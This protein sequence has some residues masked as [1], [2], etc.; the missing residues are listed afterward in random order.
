MM[1]HTPEGPVLTDPNFWAT[2]DH[3]ATFTKFRQKAPVVW[4]PEP[5]TSWNPGGGRGFWS[6][7]SHDLVSTVSKSTDLFGSRYGT[8]V[9]DQ[10]QAVVSA[11]GML[12]MDAPEHT[13]LRSIV[14]RV[15]T[16]R[17]VGSMMTDI[18]G[19]AERLV[20]RLVDLGSFDFAAEVADTYPAGIVAD[21][22]GVE[23]ADLQMLVGLTKKI[24]G[25]IPEVS[26]R[27]NLEMINYGTELSNR[28]LKHPTADLVSTI[29]HAEV[30]GARLTPEEVGT[31]FALL[32]TAGIE[33]T[34]TALNH[35]MVALDRYPDQ[36]E[37]WKAD[38]TAHSP[39]AVEEVFRWASPVRR[40]RRTA[41]QDTTIADTP[42]AAG[43]KV[44][45]WYVSANRDEAVFRD[46]ERF[47][48]TRNPNPHVAFGGGGN[49][50][51]LGANLARAEVRAFLEL[52]LVRAPGLRVS[53]KVR[54]AANDAF[55]VID[56]LP[57]T[58]RT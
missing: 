34:G 54:Y 58:I 20:D 26:H 22:M 47:D 3:A 39:F 52:L 29:V 10:D 21:F 7:T 42:I 16:P 8:E 56:E 46:P 23:P 6:V 2:G 38:F 45:L 31:F 57:M 14:S 5:A 35:S 32:L 37:L 51:C 12:N 1:T 50:F 41:L 48:I 4:H 55:N 27:S 44:V 24:L 49:H 11:A 43:D 17:R 15:F 30:D 18:N 40:F 33:T 53:D 28:R 13:R 36:R 9:I 25:P 19:R